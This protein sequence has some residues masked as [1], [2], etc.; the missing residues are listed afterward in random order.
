MHS[1]FLR[2][3]VRL[4]T[5]PMSHSCRKCY[6]SSNRLVSNLLG[7]L[8]WTTINKQKK[9]T[10]KINAKSQLEIDFDCILYRMHLDYLDSCLDD[11]SMLTFGKFSWFHRALLFSTDLKFHTMYLRKCC[12]D[13]ETINNQLL[14]ILHVCSI[15]N[16]IDSLQTDDYL[17][18]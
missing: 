14:R 13:T 10:E 17:F 7:S 16:S 4:C 18:M 2:Q 3:I 1:H 6:V 11:I 15:T 12:N 8:L 5:I 9:K